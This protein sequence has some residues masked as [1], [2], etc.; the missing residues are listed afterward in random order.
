NQSAK[1]TD[2]GTMAHIRLLKN[3]REITIDEC[4]YQLVWVYKPAAGKQRRF[5]VAPVDEFENN[6]AFFANEADFFKMN[7]FAKNMRELYNKENSGF[8]EAAPLNEQQASRQ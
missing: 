1:N 5:Y 2:G 6:P 7:D 8:P 4:G 3:G